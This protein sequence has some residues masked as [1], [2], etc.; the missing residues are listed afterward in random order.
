MLKIKRIFLLYIIT[1]LC[2][3]IAAVAQRPGRTARFASIVEIENQITN[4]RCAI[5]RAPTAD[6]CIPQLQGEALTTF[7]NK[8]TEESNSVNANYNNNRR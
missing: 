7:R 8:Y 3:E 5:Q 4:L 6:P 1:S 2:T